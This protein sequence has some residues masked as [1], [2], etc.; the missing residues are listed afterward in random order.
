MA[1]L[2]L[3]CDNYGLDGTVESEAVEQGN[4]NEGKFLTQCPLWKKH[5]TQL[6]VAVAYS[7]QPI[8][9]FQSCPSPSMVGLI[10]NVR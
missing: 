2:W 9:I 5:Q 6:V 8:L 7:P 4:W 1:L 3:Y 10:K